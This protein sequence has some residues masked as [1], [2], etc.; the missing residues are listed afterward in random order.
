MTARWIPYVLTVAGAYL[1]SS[2]WGFLI[3][4]ILLIILLLLPI[5]GLLQLLL[6]RRQLRVQ[7][8]A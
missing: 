8:Q 6:V 2:Y 4:K 3:F 5:A 1:A 7:W